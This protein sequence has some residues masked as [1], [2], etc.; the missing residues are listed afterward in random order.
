MSICSN[1]LFLRILSFFET[2]LGIMRFVVP[3]GLIIKLAI[4]MYKNMISNDESKIKENN[5]MAVKRIIAAIIVFL[6]PT[7]VN[8]V[9]AF[10][11]NVMSD[12]YNYRGCLTEIDNIDYF[13]ELQEKEEEL[14]EQTEKEDIINTYNSLQVQEAELI[15]NNATT[16]SSEG[17]F[18][19]KKYKLSDSQLKVIAKI[20]QA[21]QGTA[22]GAAWEASLMANRYE[23]W[24]KKYGS[25]YVYV[26]TS[27]WWAPAKNGTYAKIKLKPAVLN[28]V[29]QVLVE[30]QRLLPLYIDQH[31]WV[32]DLYKLVVNGKTITGRSN[33]KKH[34]NYIRDVTKIYSIYA[35]GSY[36]V[37]YAHPRTDKEA[38]PFG[39]SPAAK[40]K[41]KKMESAT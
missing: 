7:L 33:M 13:I 15:K 21:E 19:G 1:I 29:K 39:Y 27:K 28:S 32:G 3:I 20:C 18:L 36:Y 5:S 12:D 4:D 26:L 41:V 37:Y 2:F 38:D 10:I 35:E 6:I 31:G 17:G 23:L 16:I 40:R 9:M 22:K 30:G 25:F 8:S 14:K 24:G 34:S 11:E